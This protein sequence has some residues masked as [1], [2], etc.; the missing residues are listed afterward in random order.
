MTKPSGL[1]QSVDRAFSILEALSDGEI[2][3]V[4]LSKRVGLN[5][6]TVYRL[7]N[8]LISKGY[9]SQNF[10]NSK[11]KLTL[12]TL[13]IGSKVQSNLN[14]VNIAKP[15]IQQ[16]SLDTNEVV[17]LVHIENNELI[18]IDK[19]ESNN[20]IRMHSYIGKSIPLYSSAVGKAY[21]AHLKENDFLSIWNDLQNNIIE[22]TRNTI[23][24]KERMLKEIAAIRKQGY[25]IDNEENEEGVICVASPIFNFNKELNYAISISTPKMRI[26][27]EK[28]SFFGSLVKETSKKI[29]K[30][31]GYY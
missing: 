5:K 19:I 17:H 8:T 6:S 15:Y 26:N 27:Q 25:A 4:E 1:V 28:I 3:L 9:V 12:K 10:D 16:L 18:Y 22:F 21:L 31:L 24:T 29:S 14:I 11:Y 20:T 7:L 30:E 13:Q 2:G 23:T